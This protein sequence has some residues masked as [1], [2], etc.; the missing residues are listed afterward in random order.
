MEW[1]LAR[2]IISLKEH[3]WNVWLDFYCCKD[4]K[5]YLISSRQDEHVLHVWG[6]PSPKNAPVFTSSV[7]MDICALKNNLYNYVSLKSTPLYKYTLY[8]A[9]FYYKSTCLRI[10]YWVK[11]VINFVWNFIKNYSPCQKNLTTNGKVALDI[12]VTNTYVMILFHQVSQ[13]LHTQVH[14][15]L[16]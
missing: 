6:S 14:F 16:E 5:P 4:H 11:I 3:F 15:I 1:F 9:M 2:G 7:L 13:H 8:F 12:W 10:Q